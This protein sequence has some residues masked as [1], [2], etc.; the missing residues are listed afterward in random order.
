[1]TSESRQGSVLWLPGSLRVPVT[2]GLLVAVNRDE[3][4]KWELE[5]AM[6]RAPGVKWR[7]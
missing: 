2:G 7:L 6:H 5:W 1:M 4:C 3:L